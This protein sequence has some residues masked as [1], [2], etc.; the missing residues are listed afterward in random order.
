MMK[1]IIIAIIV[2]SFFVISFSMIEF[3][4]VAL[5]TTGC[6]R[7]FLD[8]NK[9]ETTIEP[10]GSVNYTVIYDATS[11]TEACPGE[12]LYIH[13]NPKET[14]P[15]A[16]ICINNTLRTYPVSKTQSYST[17]IYGTE[18][19]YNIEV[20]SDP[21]PCG[22]GNGLYYNQMGEPV[23]VTVNIKAGGGS[24]PPTT[25][26][27]RIFS[28]KATTVAG[29]KTGNFDKS[30]TWTFKPESGDPALGSYQVECGIDG[31]KFDNGKS[32]RKL[33]QGYIKGT[34]Y[35]IRVTPY[36]KN[37]TLEQI[38][39]P[40][41]I[42]IS[43]AKNGTEPPDKPPVDTTKTPLVD[44]KKDVI[45]FTPAVRDE[46]FALIQRIVNVLFSLIATVSIIFIIV[47]GFRLAFS[48]GSQEAV[49][50][51]KK[52][53]TWAIAGLAVALLAFAIIKAVANIFY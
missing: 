53:I 6:K 7:V 37:P 23:K 3:P 12:S 32:T 15:G 47:G 4:S 16:G 44:L 36:S 38:G 52:T 25:A 8:G 27:S 22:Q 49:T 14:R 24:V 42:T 1:K 18:G 31:L 11:P 30:V 5:A 10:G 20:Y 51:G 19:T 45:G 48:Q 41:E 50:A 46:P 40:A 28:L 39:A 13:V 35:T 33:C 21:T 9:S 2:A 17:A 34:Q 26:G 29:S 43:E